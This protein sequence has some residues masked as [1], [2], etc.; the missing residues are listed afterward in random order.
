MSS[1]CKKSYTKRNF[2]HP[3]SAI[4]SLVDCGGCAKRLAR[5][6]LP[7][8]FSSP[9]RFS[10]PSISRLFQDFH[11]KNHHLAKSFRRKSWSEAMSPCSLQQLCDPSHSVDPVKCLTQLVRKMPLALFGLFSFFIHVASHILQTGCGEQRGCSTI[12]SAFGFESLN[13]LCCLFLPRFSLF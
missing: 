3:R 9:S 10:I 7:T 12:T 4:R 1:S 8:A 11:G 5:E 2:G 13:V 6:K